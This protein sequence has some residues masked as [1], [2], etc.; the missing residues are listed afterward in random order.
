MA[1]DSRLAVQG[2]GDVQV[3]LGTSPTQLL[4]LQ[5]V[6]FIPNLQCS[7]VALRL[8][9]RQGIYWDT[10]RDP[11]LLRRKADN[12]TICALQELHRQYVLEYNAN[13]NAINA[14]FATWT[15]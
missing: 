6:A 4:T 1:G 5:N 15:N 9:M 7:L 12:S 14:S 8:I 13:P 10:R 11:T 2:Y 3:T